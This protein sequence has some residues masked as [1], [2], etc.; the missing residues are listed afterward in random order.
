MRRLQL[1]EALTAE[2]NRLRGESVAKVCKSL[3]ESITWLKRR[4]AAM[5]KELDRTIRHNPEF[6]ALSD[7]VP[8]VPGVGTHT[9]HMITA[10]LP[11]LGRL[12]RRQIAALVGIAPLNRDGGKSHGRRFCWGGR[13]DVRSALYTAA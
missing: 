3:R 1:I 2:P 6:S 4:I 9:A 12:D 8:S 13:A 5:D 10:G 7:R 11:E